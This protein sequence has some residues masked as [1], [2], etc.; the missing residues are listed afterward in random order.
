MVKENL[1]RKVVYVNSSV[2]MNCALVVIFG[3]LFVSL[4]MDMI[5]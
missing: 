3:I 4:S 5:S 1:G 2:K